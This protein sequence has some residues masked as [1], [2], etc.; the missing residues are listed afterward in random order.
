[1]PRAWR[2]TFWLLGGLVGLGIFFYFLMLL[3][4]D[5]GGMFAG[6]FGY[7]VD[8][9]LSSLFFVV[10][11]IGY[12][13]FVVLIFLSL[14]YPYER[15][16]KLNEADRHVSQMS[17]FPVSGIFSAPEVTKG[18]DGWNWRMIYGWLVALGCG[19]PILVL[20]YLVMTMTSSSGDADLLVFFVAGPIMGFAQL[21]L[22]ILGLIYMAGTSRP[23]VNKAMAAGG[24][25]FVIVSVV[26]IGQF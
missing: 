15:R 26:L 21:C 4:L 8:E 6:V 9:F 18:A 12:I 5:D 22:V 11:P 14:L 25:I 23:V 13:A 2:V 7:R 24:I 10:V 20:I 1:M 16:R 3:F 19:L 17:T